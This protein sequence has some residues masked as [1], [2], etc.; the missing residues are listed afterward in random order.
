MDFAERSGRRLFVGE[1]MVEAEE[2]ELM[3]AV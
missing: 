3:R 2:K 1:V